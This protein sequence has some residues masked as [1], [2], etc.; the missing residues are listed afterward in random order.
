M[1]GWW[2]DALQS[3]RSLVRRPAAP[4]AIVGILALGI[5]A[6][7]ATFAVFNTVL[8]RPIPGVEDPSGL[9][10]VRVQPKDRSRTFSGFSREH[11][12]EMRAADTGL[13]GLTSEW[14][15]DGWVA[16]SADAEPRLI[17]LAGV[18]REYFSVLGLRMRL[19][20]A[21]DDSEVETPGHRVV[22]ISEYLWRTA[23]DGRADIVGRTI[24]L[25]G[26]PF[27][28]AGVVERYRGWSIVFKH[29]LWLPMA[30][31]PTID[32]RT[33]P[34]KLWD[35]GYF[36]FFGRLRAG[37]TVE[38]VEPRLGAVFAHVDEA[39]AT[40]R[41]VAMMPVVYHGAVDIS[42]RSIE[43]RL[44]EIFR[45]AGIGAFLL[46]ALASANAAN[47]LL[48]RSAQ[49]RS[50]LAL[51][52]AL[53]G[54][55][56]R[57]MRLL[58]IESA[59]QAIAAGALGLVIAI[60]LAGMFR[61]MPLL[62]YLPA[63]DE[64]GIDG[65]VL[66]FS[67][68]I[69][70]TTVLVFGVVPAWLSTSI[71]PRRLLVE[72]RTIARST[73]WLRS[74][75]VAAQVALSL[76]LVVSAVVLFR[77]LDNLR[78]QDFGFTPAHVVEVDFNAAE[79]GYTAPQR[80]EL[81]RQAVER[82]AALPGI[83][84]AGFS[85]PAPISTS[86]AEQT[87]RPREMAAATPI[88]AT[89]SMVSHGYFD[90]LSIPLL[91]GR[92][93]RADE[94]MRAA[95]DARPVIISLALAQKL[96][97]STPAVG[98]QIALDTGASERAAEI[99]GVVGDVKWADLRAEPRLMVYRPSDPDFVYGTLIVR[100]ARPPDQ[101]IAAVRSTMKEIAPG[102]PLDD[103]GTLDADL[104][105][106]L[107]E[108]RVIARLMGMVA[109]IAGLVALAGLYAIVAHLVTE[110]TRELGIRIALGAPA[111]SIARIVLRPVI[112]LTAVGA[113][114]GVGLILLSTK[115]LAARV[116]HIS[117]SDPFTV[118]VAG[119]ALLGAALI[120]GW[121]P[122]RRATKIDPAITLKSDP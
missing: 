57:L 27:S 15:G 34:E 86:S 26:E 53:G 31:W 25:N 98:R 84:R 69:S 118:A 39:A 101:V 66:A 85:S 103:V 109:V 10:T 94:F 92:D 105:H 76:A 97:G 102:V 67:A 114:A 96:F 80:A 12:V 104:D 106:Q 90:T 63:L 58:V 95:A 16:A 115:V 29:D 112:V 41:R 51:R 110:R 75:L 2:P 17:G 7:D 56:G 87:V 113:A 82:V 122:A 3:W 20:R 50:E 49:R 43:T 78:T 32:R 71:D 45:V 88:K 93:F 1:R 81:F 70:A 13:A 100:S 30:E 60:V 62:P 117:P 74:G 5:G 121:R 18:A 52:A 47:L 21:L 42:Q 91:A 120:A 14:R 64:I 11:L 48:V 83:E 37:S 72:T 79:R 28:V 119:M 35:S 23:F 111:S 89:S 9:V 61:G 107:V 24:L 99:V 44:F 46:L 40:P 55:R 33:K 4:A 116:F 8:F 108:E 38:S 59:E 73:H 22:V 54:G 68:I 6:T 77:S 65:R 36:G 19:G